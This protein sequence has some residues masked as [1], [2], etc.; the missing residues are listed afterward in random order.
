MPGR[1]E[2]LR[3]QANWDTKSIRPSL[4]NGNIERPKA[5]MRPIG[6]S[7]NQ[8]QDTP[9]YGPTPGAKGGTDVTPG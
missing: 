3:K 8:P 1:R 6:H 7:A 9:G 4:P 5:L 2:D